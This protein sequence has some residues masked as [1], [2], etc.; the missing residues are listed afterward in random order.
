MREY[1][2]FTQHLRGG[3]TYRSHKQVELSR[4]NRLRA[5]SEYPRRGIQSRV[6]GTP[7]GT[8]RKVRGEPHEPNY[9]EPDRFRLVCWAE[10]R[11]ISRQLVFSWSQQS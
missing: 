8:R 2:E 1:A 10:N 4:L 7:P 11:T 3:R 9:V 5:A 6:F